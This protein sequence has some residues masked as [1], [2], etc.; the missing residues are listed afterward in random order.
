[1]GE[2]PRAE[3]KSIIAAKTRERKTI[4]CLIVYL[5]CVVKS[6]ARIRNEQK[7]KKKSSAAK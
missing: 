7:P 4:L 3:E 5:Y 6:I 1:M 2:A